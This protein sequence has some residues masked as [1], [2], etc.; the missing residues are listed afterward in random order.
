MQIFEESSNFTALVIPSI[1]SHSL[2]MSL[3]IVDL[4]MLGYLGKGHLAAGSIGISIFN[5]VWVF[6]EGSLTA[7]ETF[8]AQ[9]FGN[10]N[11]RD[12]RI[13]TCIAFLAVCISCSIGSGIL[14]GIP[15]IINII[16][17][18]KAHIAFKVIEQVMILAPSLWLMGF[19]RVIEKYFQAQNI[20]M[21]SLYCAGIG[22]IFNAITNYIFMFLLGTGFIGCGI[23]TLLSRLLM[24]VMIIW[25]LKQT[26]D[27]KE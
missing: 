3:W 26:K 11:F 7:Q 16:L 18:E 10:K 9:S 5:I 24:L 6:I 2:D 17:P 12:I 21:P 25:H 19:F 27:F 22:T 15:Y 4:I 1:L 13:W 20:M 8:A 23:S 14:F